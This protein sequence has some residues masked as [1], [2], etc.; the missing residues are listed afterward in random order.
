M[1]QRGGDPQTEQA[2]FTGGLPAVRRAL[3]YLRSYKGEVFGSFAALLLASAA[4]L[5]APQLIAYA[6]DGGI[7]PRRSSVIL[8]AVLGIDG[9]ALLRGLLPFWQG[10]R[11]ERA[12]QGVA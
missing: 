10:Y 6:I 12:W 8:L 1:E 11:R 7:A 5:A 4:S 2:S 3:L 9:A